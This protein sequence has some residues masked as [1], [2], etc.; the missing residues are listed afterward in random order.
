MANPVSSPISTQMSRVFKPAGAI[1][2]FSK[3]QDDK[4]AAAGDKKP[5]RK[6]DAAIE[7]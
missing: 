6:M 3:L 2:V 4:L 1:G 5:K 7:G